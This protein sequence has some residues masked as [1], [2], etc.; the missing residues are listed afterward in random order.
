MKITFCRP[1]NATKAFYPLFASPVKAGF[2]SPA[3]DYIE[4]KLDLNELMIKHPAATFF[5]RVDGDSMS[6]AGI[7]SG[8]ILVVDRSASP[9]SG[10]III[11]I[12]GGEFTVKRIKMQGKEI[13][14]MPENPD[15][16]PIKV[17]EESDFEIWGI[18]THVIHSC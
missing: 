7:H 15:F 3:D 6:G 1:N 4:Q 11:A 13:Y 10:K 14:L 12:L 5:V 9:S 16:P 2:P 8:D 18:V 17:H